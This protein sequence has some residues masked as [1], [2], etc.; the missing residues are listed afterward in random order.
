MMLEESHLIFVDFKYGIK[1]PTLS[2][3]EL[4]PFSRMK[5]FVPFEWK[6]EIMEYLFHQY[7]SQSTSQRSLATSPHQYFELTPSFSTACLNWSI[8]PEI[9]VD[10]SHILLLRT[11]DPPRGSPSVNLSRIVF[12]CLTCS[13]LDSGGTLSRHHSSNHCLNSIAYHAKRSI[14]C[15]K[16]GRKNVDILLSRLYL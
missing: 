4:Y 3:G 13:P 15:F 9:R 1:H 12:P 14:C 2:K 5:L 11:R 16:P 7:I 10:P 8:S 6:I